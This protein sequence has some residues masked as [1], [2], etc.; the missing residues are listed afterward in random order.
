MTVIE[1]RTTDQVLSAVILPKI[2]PNNHNSLKLSVTFDKSWDGYGKS[3]I[4]FTKYDSVPWEKVLDVN[5]SCKVPPEVLTK[6]GH[7][8]IGLKGIKVNGEVKTSTLL[9]VKISEGTPLVIVSDPTTDVYSQLLANYAVLAGR[10]NSAINAVSNSTEVTDIRVGADGKT[11]S[12]AG[13]AV[14]SQFDNVN[15]AIDEIRGYAYM[16]EGELIIDGAN[17]QISTNS[18]LL[19]TSDRTFAYVTNVSAPIAFD[20]T[21]ASVR[22]IFAVK[23]DAGGYE[24]RIGT[25]TEMKT[26][27]NVY[28]ICGYYSKQLIGGNFSPNLQV[29]INGVTEDAAKV[30]YNGAYTNFVAAFNE[31]DE[32]LNEKYQ[33]LIDFVYNISSVNENAVEFTANHLTPC[34]VS[35]DAS[36][37][38][39][40]GTNSKRLAVREM[41]PSYNSETVEITMSA[42]VNY[43]CN[44]YLFDEN[45]T[46]IGSA[47][48]N[49]SKGTIKAAIDAAYFRVMIARTNGEDIDVTEL[50]K[51]RL[52]SVKRK[53]TLE[54]IPD[55]LLSS[56]TTH[57]KLLG[58]SITQGMGSTGYI[59]YTIVEGDE[60]ISVRG[61]GHEYPYKDENYIEGDYL[62][63]L[64]ARRWYESTSSTGWSNRLREYF[65][66]KFD[67]VVKNYGMSG[68]GS[69]NLDTLCKPLVTED[70]DI[71]ILMIGTN[72]RTT[73]EKANFKNNVRN[74][75][76]DLLENDKRVILMGSVPVSV[77]NE[78]GCDYH[79]EDVNNILKTVAYDCNVPFISVYDDFI[80]YCDSRD[81]D[82]DT[83]LSDGLHPNDD[84]YEVMFRIISKRLGI[85]TKRK[86]ATW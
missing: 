80:D 72:D 43:A 8:Y 55:I 65:E 27:K 15:S 5:N 77:E 67:C 45:K 18:L 56:G 76:N 82:V 36:G 39:G 66:S 85:S 28:Y 37:E 48:H 44:L 68:I 33:K 9:T 70:D 41:I 4:F 49:G 84:G 6:E 20:S 75:V 61:N 13:E 31:C 57:I 14:R 53:T 24:I 22:S 60:E 58:D 26:Y 81:M 21:V 1:A 10:F 73:T 62:G 32:K 52:H 59:G 64:G 30:T 12:T 63:E 29:T 69:A 34:N 3:A 78:A 7:L 16:A 86:G 83:L 40:S 11:Y 54:M 35:V 51:I 71:I 74:F 47:Y 46:F 50:V 2:A 25:D 17:A 79:M 19:L 38:L 42:D 23:T